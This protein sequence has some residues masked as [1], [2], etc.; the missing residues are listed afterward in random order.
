LDAEYKVLQGKHV[1]HGFGRTVNICSRGLLVELEGRVPGL[2]SIDLSIK[3]PFL[4]EGSIPLKLM[5]RG[6]IVRVDGRRIAVEF[7][8]REFHTASVGTSKSAA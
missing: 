7:L 4:L 8:A 6:R 2:G 3:W 5:V 1:K